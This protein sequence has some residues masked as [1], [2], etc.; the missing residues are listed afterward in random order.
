VKLYRGRVVAID[1][2]GVA[3]DIG[4]KSEG[5]VPIVEFPNIDELKPGDEI[6]VYLQSVE[7]REGRLVL[8]RKRADFIRIW[9]RIV[10]AHETAEI[11]QGKLPA[12]LRA[13]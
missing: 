6:E 12:G 1:D 4:F 8:S 7:D 13:A 2:D 11:L 3:I 5:I 10:R 9:E